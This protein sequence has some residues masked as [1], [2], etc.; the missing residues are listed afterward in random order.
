MALNTSF[1]LWSGFFSS[2]QEGRHDGVVFSVLLPDPC[3][4]LDEQVHFLRV[5]EVLMGDLRDAFRMDLLIADG[6]SR[7]EGSQDGDLAAGVVPF[8][9]RFGIA[10]R[11]ALFLGLLQA[12]L[13]AASVLGHMGE[14]VIGGPVQDAADQLD[15]FRRERHVQGTD[16]GIPP[17]TLAS[18]R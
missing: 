18:N 4:Q 17:P 6:L 14:D 1:T 13:K 11:I 10:L 3:Q 15:L 16:D 8:H 7:H 12:F 2:D 5:Q 9:I